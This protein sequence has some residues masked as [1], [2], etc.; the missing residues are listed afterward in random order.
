MAANKFQHP[1]SAHVLAATSS[2]ATF[3]AASAG[4][5][6]SGG[7]DRVVHDQIWPGLEA[8]PG[9]DAGSS[10]RVKVGRPPLASRLLHQSQSGHD[11]GARLP[12]RVAGRGT[13]GVT[14]TAM[15]PLHAP[16]RVQVSTPW[17]TSVPHL[18]TCA[19][20]P[21]GGADWREWSLRE[22]G[23]PRKEEPVLARFWRTPTSALDKKQACRRRRQTDARVRERG[24]LARSDDCAVAHMEQ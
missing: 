1:A 8:P 24:T 16:T 2:R 10:N 21:A 9:V 19:T 11:V 3:R 7:R 15:A 22:P 4:P 18:A 12:S 20:G 23:L 6:V 13:E 14:T 5:L 17:T